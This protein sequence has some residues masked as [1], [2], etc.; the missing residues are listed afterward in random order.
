VESIIDYYLV[1]G[2]SGVALDFVDELEVAYRHLAL[3]PATGSP[4]YARQLGIEGLRTWP[5]RRFPYIVFYF[6]Q[7]EHVEIWRVLHGQR[8]LP[9]WLL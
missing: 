6:A 4:R 3:Q 9:A 2:G 1:E 5:L 7:P 8:D